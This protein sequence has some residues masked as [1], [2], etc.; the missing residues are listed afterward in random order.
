VSVNILAQVHVQADVEPHV[1]VASINKH[2]RGR[3]DLG[4]ISRKLNGDYVITVITEVSEMVPGQYGTEKAVLVDVAKA[5]GAVDRKARFS[6]ARALV[7]DW[8]VPD[9]EKAH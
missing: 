8:Y 6:G 1:L 5:V 2:V 4:H 3:L 9:D 7:T